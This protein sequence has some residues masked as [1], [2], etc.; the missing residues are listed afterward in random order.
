MK[1]IHYLTI[2]A[3]LLFA[4]SQPETN[5]KASVV[6]YQ[7]IP[8]FNGEVLFENG[9]QYSAEISA[10]EFFDNSIIIANDKVHPDFSPVYTAVLKNDSVK[11]LTQLHSKA[12]QNSRKIED[13]TTTEDFVIFMSAFSHTLDGFNTILYSPKT[14]LYNAQLLTYPNPKA[15]ESKENRFIFNDIDSSHP[16]PFQT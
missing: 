4:C 12:I 15:A 13:L 16:R 10:V 5:Y 1:N 9:W 6:T 11:Y 2:G 8:I 7:N 3:L 14:D